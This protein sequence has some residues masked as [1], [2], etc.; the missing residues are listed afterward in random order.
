MSGLAVRRDRRDLKDP[1]AQQGRMARK[2]TRAILEILGRRDQRD[3]KD[4]L[5]RQGR[6]AQRV[7]REMLGLLDRKE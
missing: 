5:A 1:L 6:R 4:R 7:T 2:V 3:L